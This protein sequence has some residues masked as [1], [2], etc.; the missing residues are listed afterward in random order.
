MTHTFGADSLPVPASVERGSGLR[1]LVV[2]D[3]RTLREGCASVLQ[4]DGHNVTS[5]GRGEEALD[6]VRRRRFDI[7]LVDLY[8]SPI[9]GM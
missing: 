3:D 4:M 8:M 5:T 7:V 2:D 1:L 6:L 9:T